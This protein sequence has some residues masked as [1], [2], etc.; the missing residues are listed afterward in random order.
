[1]KYFDCHTHTNYEPL[2]NELEDIF[3]TNIENN[4]GINIVGCSFESS[5]LAV[6]HAR[7]NKLSYATIGI[8]PENAKYHL[9]IKNEISRLEELYLSNKDKIISIGECGLDYYYESTD[10]IKLLQKELF[11]AQIELALKLDLPVMMHIRDAH[12]DAIEI[13]KKYKDTNLKFIVH[14]FS[15][16]S[17]ELNK[18]LELNCYYSVGGAA[19]FKPNESLRQTIKQIPLNRL[20][21]ETDA[22]W[23]SPVPYR[24]KTNYPS[25]VIVINEFLSN[26]FEISIDE[27]NANLM[28]NVYSVFKLKC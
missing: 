19:T 22:P 23:L 15:A 8:H 1:M 10:E 27:L 18:Y 17:D 24:G 9:N 5:V 7:Q 25:N 4:L 26:L 20:L 13:I 2:L 16:N 3:K 21:T 11:I 28:K 14:C 12:L 6:E